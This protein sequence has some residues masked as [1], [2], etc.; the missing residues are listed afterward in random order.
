M[1]RRNDMWTTPE[2]R[3]KFWHY[4]QINLKFSLNTLVRQP[5]SF[6]RINKLKFKPNDNVLFTCGEDG[7][8]KSW[9]LLSSSSSISSNMNWIY[10][11]CNGYRDMIPID[12]DLIDL[13]ENNCLVAV[14][15]NHIN[16]LW[17]LNAFYSLMI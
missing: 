8:F 5:H 6:D 16:T 7:C 9:Q 3:L 4:D 1:E 13:D 11:T 15:F 10:S 2:T 17:V 12:L 14:S